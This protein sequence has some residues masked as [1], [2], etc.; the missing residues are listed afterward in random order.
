MPGRMVKNRFLPFLKI[1]ALHATH[2]D[3][4]TTGYDLRYETQMDSNLGTIEKIAV[5]EDGKTVIATAQSY[6]DHGAVFRQCMYMTSR[7]MI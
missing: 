7:V 5:S 2:G 6:C 1:L 3:A 4:A